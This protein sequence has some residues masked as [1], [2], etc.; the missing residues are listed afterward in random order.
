MTS[1][2]SLPAAALD[3]PVLFD[4]QSLQNPASA[5]RGIGRYVSELAL[6]L[7]TLER[8]TTT[9]LLNRSLPV[10]RQLEPLMALGD[11][12]AGDTVGSAGRLLHVPSPFEPVRMRDLWPEQLRHLPLVV[13]VHD[14]IPAV[15]PALYLRDPRVRRW[16]K[17]RLGFVQRA[18]LVLVPSEA[19][20]H[21]VERRLG[22]AARKVVVTGEAPPTPFSSAGGRQTFEAA[23][24]RLPRL[25]PG[26]V[27]YT[28]GMD[29]RK[30]VWGLIHAYAK[31]DRHLQEAH[32]LVVVC[33]LTPE[34][35][36]QA[37]ERL[38]RLRI[39]DRVYFTGYISDAQLALLYQHAY[40]FAFPSLYE[41][42]GLPVAEAIAAG[43]PVVAADS[44]AV[45]ELVDPRAL[46]NPYDEESIA[47]SLVAGLTDERFRARLERAT[48]PPHHTWPEVARRT[49][50]AYSSVRRS[51]TRR[52][53]RTRPRIALVSPLPPDPSGV[54]DYTF[55]LAAEL[56]AYAPIDVFVENAHDAIAP[57][58]VEVRRLVAFDAVEHLRAGYS[59]VLCSLG[60]SATHIGALALLRRRPATVL[61]HDVRLTDL[62]NVLT[63]TRHDLEP[64]RLHTIIRGM[65]EDRY[66]KK[67]GIL[68][69]VD[70]KMADRH[71]LLMA[72]EAIRRSDRFLVHS[73]YAATLAALDAREADDE[74][75]QVV[76]FGYPE[77]SLPP[78]PPDAPPLIA[79]F[80][81]AT[82]LKQID[83]LIFAMARV[84]RELPNVE[85]AIVGAVTP[86]EDR[87]RY[88]AAVRRL[89]LAA[90]TTFT[91]RTDTSVYRELLSRATVCVQLRSSSY[92]ESSAALADCLAAGKP[93][94]VTDIGS[95]RELPDDAVVKLAPDV[96]ADDLAAELIRLARDGSRR[97]RLAAAAS[98]HARRN[99]FAA[100]AA[101][102]YRALHVEAS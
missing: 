47:A 23:R 71:G 8:G 28:G 83:T 79:T 37:T 93:T 3:G 54:A 92:G 94:V 58:G 24:A 18:D 85:L 56:R 88:E 9:F 97:E 52:R 10:P 45:R 76:P 91:G 101:A 86:A 102:V 31:I 69:G 16:Y 75:I 5:Q 36:A 43:A 57:E 65:Y 96:T 66:P 14:L 89:G 95:A 49:S 55:R 48:L 46:F 67:L 70:A 20:R 84:A 4:A 34:E 13:T 64:R 27:L 51:P 74:K 68:R 32:Q 12:R 1:T 30:N 99:S 2:S 59:A 80:G 17:A 26:Y 33:A 19:T 87:R 41:G 60:N 62:Y 39:A 50:D 22:V 77:L 40:L 35:H 44:S 82:P 42:Y 90:R 72:R 29:L 21:D 7:T 53:R 78:S 6:A 11:V 61:A 15:L 25:E 38:E 63:A 98:A 73:R 81:F 100:A